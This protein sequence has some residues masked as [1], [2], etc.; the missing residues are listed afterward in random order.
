MRAWFAILTAFPLS[1]LP[2]ACTEVGDPAL[3]IE[4]P[5]EVPSG[6]LSFARHIEPIFQD[7]GCIG[8][9]GSGGGFGGLD[10][11][12]AAAVLEGGDGG[13]AIVPCDASASWLWQRVRDCE[14]PATGGCLDDIEVD[15]IAR[16]IDQGGRDAFEVGVCP[17]P[18]LD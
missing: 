3:V 9:H 12:T 7:N 8:C 6:P 18:P 14:M 17:D 11:T 10:V 16:W 13:P 15:T 4:H 2:T 5:L 1:F